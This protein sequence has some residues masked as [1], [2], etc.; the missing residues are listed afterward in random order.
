MENLVT[1]TVRMIIGKLTENLS[2]LDLRNDEDFQ[3]FL[4]MRFL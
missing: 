4:E 1:L 3:E 2:W